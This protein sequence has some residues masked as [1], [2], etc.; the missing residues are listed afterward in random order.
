MKYLVWIL[1]LFAAA[2]ALT[3]A[4]H[5]PAYVLLVYPPY[6]IELSLTL[7]IVILLLTFVLGYGLVRLIIGVLQLPAYV[8]TFRL[9]SVKSKGR[10]LLNEE[11]GAFFEGRYAAAEKAAARAME[12]GDSSA[13]HPIIAARSAHELREYKKRDAYLSAA[14]GKT[15]GDSTMRL[16]TTSKFLL[17]QH[18]PRGALV[19]LQE[20]RNSGVKG[21]LGA[22]SLELKAHQQAGNWDGVLNVLNELEKRESIDT[23][24]AAQ[25]RQQ[26]WLG[27]I[28]Q[29]EDLAGLTTCLKSIPDDFK[30]RR[31]IAAAAARALIQHGGDSFAQQLLSDSLNEQW[32]SELVA[33]YGDCQSNDVV[34]QIEQAEKW[35]NQH[36]QDAALLL[37]LG[38]LCLHQKLWGKAR[39]YL[40]ASNSIASSHAAYTA[41]GQLAERLGKSDEAFKYYQQAMELERG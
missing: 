34:A 28:R 6:R 4:S 29:Q 24:M 41:L 31:K 7:F 23:P 20:L 27:K 3:T 22:L 37:A 5:N 14:E 30:R 8:R 39:S 2:V 12:L 21:H 36:K 17:D 10:E 32:D 1:G 25:L 16:M 19:A 15:I 11:L 18:D 9:E 26:A 13:L 35:L 40:D 38:K 33:L